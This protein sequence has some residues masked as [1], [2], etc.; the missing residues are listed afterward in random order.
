MTSIDL[1]FAKATVSTPSPQFRVQSGSLG[2]MQK[3]PSSPTD[4]RWFLSM[5]LMYR[6]ISSAQPRR[7]FV[8]QLGEAGRPPRQRGSL[9]S[10]HVMIVGS[11]LYL[12]PVIV[13]TRFRRWA[14]WALYHCR[15]TGSM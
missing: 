2:L 12:T 14:T 5:S 8:L 15:I 9:P 3:K 6:D 4:T 11:S 1:S 10:S 7:V 13:L